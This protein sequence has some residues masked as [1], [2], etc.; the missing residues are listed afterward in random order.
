MKTVLEFEIEEYEKTLSA[1]EPSDLT[2]DKSSY[3]NV[4]SFGTTSDNYIS[5]TK[6]ILLSN[7]SLE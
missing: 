6:S 7:E 1:L 2:E 4:W 3:F 5:T